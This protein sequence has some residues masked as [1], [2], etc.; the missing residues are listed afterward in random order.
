MSGKSVEMQLFEMRSAVDTNGLDSAIADRDV[1]PA[2]VIAVLGKTCGTGLADDPERQAVEESILRSLCS[3]SLESPEAV[4][5]RV[6]FI[7]SSGAVG[8]IVPHIAVI[9]RSSRESTALASKRLTVGVAESEPLL[10]SEIGK[11]AHMDK[12][13]RAVKTALHRSGVQTVDDVHCV[14]VRTPA[15]IGDDSAEVTAF[16]ERTS[17]G[18]FAAV[19]NNVEAMSY[20][21]DAA[22][23]GVAAGLG[24]IDYGAVREAAIRSDWSL[25]SSV[26]WVTAGGKRPCAEIVLLGNSESSSSQLTIGHGITRD[27]LDQEGMKHAL[28]SAGL[29]FSCCPS[30][31]DRKRVVLTI[32]KLSVP[33]GGLLR[34]LHTTMDADEDGTRIVKACGGTLLGSVIGTGCVLM[35]GGLNTHQ[36]PPGMSPIAAVISV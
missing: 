8:P 16:E 31:E 12:V 34:G 28:R 4:R 32:G 36:G 33:E 2:S 3:G 1:D 21:V 23:L 24:E 19:G 27:A 22:A 29:R 9:S 20:A 30:E 25:Y 13:S 15:S 11:M 17:G 7:L 14:L 35:S 18:S 6:R 26:A 10:P 5:R